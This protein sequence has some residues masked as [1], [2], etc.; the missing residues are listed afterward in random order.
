MPERP[1]WAQAAWECAYA[2]ALRVAKRPLVTAVMQH[3]AR[4]RVCLWPPHSA[5]S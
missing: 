4:D 2:G 1:G 3:D 5:H